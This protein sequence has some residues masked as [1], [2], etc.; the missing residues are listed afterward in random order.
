MSN[1][2]PATIP[3]GSEPI[4][5]L[6]SLRP[7]YARSPL[8]SWTGRHKS[9]FLQHFAKLRA[10][11]P[12]LL[13]IATDYLFAATSYLHLESLAP[14]SREDVAA[15]TIDRLASMQGGFP[16]TDDQYPWP[17][18]VGDDGAVVYAR[19]ALQL[20]M[21]RLG[22]ALGIELP[23]ILYQV[24]EQ[25]FGERV[26]PLDEIEDKEP[27]WSFPDI[28][29]SFGGDIWE[30]YGWAY[31]TD[32]ASTHY[33]WIG[34][35][36]SLE[37]TG[38][39]CMANL[40]WCAED[41][42]T[43]TKPVWSDFGDLIRAY[44]D[45]GLDVEKLFDRM[46]PS[47]DGSEL[48]DF[49]HRRAQLLDMWVDEFGHELFKLRVPEGHFSESRRGAFGGLPFFPVGS[50]KYSDTMI[51]NWRMFYEPAFR[52][53]GDNKP[54]L[55][56]FGGM[57]SMFVSVYEPNSPLAY[58]KYAEECEFRIEIGWING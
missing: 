26:V 9:N 38:H 20:N 46:Y 8:A 57:G 49:A 13:Q 39:L 25:K 12:K 40:A 16:W 15:H 30:A 6:I 47:G 51:Q 19:P 53:E 10:D 23:H 52:L 2:S 35:L 44:D 27:D 45:V 37:P 41:I 56:C 24:W 22:A 58:Q 34:N 11:Y 32:R 55:D 5:W 28:D 36:I 54:G 7:E 17:T 1:R 33:N 31:Q 4:D 14:I 43:G 29:E 50:E 3:N 48:E 42:F 18:E 21:K